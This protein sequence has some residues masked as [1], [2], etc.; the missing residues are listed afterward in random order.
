MSVK[1]SVPE[2]VP[3]AVGVKV[4]FATQLAEA[5]SV[6]PQVAE[7]MEKSPLIVTDDIFRVA[8]PVL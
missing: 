5:A 8:F 6:E 1:V 4:M 2:R 3:V 7:E